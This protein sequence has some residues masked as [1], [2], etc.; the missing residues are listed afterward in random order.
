[1]ARVKM[2]VWSGHLDLDLVRTLIRRGCPIFRVFCERACPE[3]VEGW[4]PPTPAAPLLTL[5]LTLLLTLPLPLTLFD[6]ALA[7]IPGL[8]IPRARRREEPAVRQQRHNSRS[9]SR[10][11]CPRSDAPV[12]QK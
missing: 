11:G 4:E 5:T 3:P 8:V 6:F 1:M 2:L 12:L 9:D 10:L 7:P